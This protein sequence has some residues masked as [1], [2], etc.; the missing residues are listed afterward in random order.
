MNFSSD[1][2][3]DYFVVGRLGL[4]P[5]DRLYAKVIAGNSGCHLFT[6]ANTCDCYGQLIV[7]GR[8][9]YVHRIAWELF[10]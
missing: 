8:N 2:P 1:A 5:V 3:S 10:N 4:R 6:G 9:T 7:Q